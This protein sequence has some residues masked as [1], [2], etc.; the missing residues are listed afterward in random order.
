[1]R[2][3]HPDDAHHVAR[4]DDCQARANLMGLDVGR[5]RARV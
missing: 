1:M 5:S 2:E 3:H 4:C